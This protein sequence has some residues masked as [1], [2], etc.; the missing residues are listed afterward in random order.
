MR[1]IL[2]KII[3]FAVD[4]VGIIISIFLAYQLR[5]VA[6]FLEKAHTIP[7][8]DYLT[9]FP[10]YIVVLS[11]F[12]YEGIYTRRYDFWHETRLILKAL[13]FS[14]I[15]VLAYLALSKT[16]GNYS[17][18]VVI[19]SFLCM[20]FLIPVLKRVVKIALYKFGLW[21]KP[22]IIYGEDDLLQREIYSNPYLGYTEANEKDPKTV[23]INSRKMDYKTLKQTIDEQIGTNH[24]VIFIP[25][26]NDFDLTQSQIYELSNVRTNLISLQNRLKSRLRRVTKLIF[27]MFLALLL[28]PLLLPILAIIA[29]LIKKE[30]PEG[31]ILFKQERLGKDGKLFLCYKF[32]T[33]KEESDEL[34]QGYLKDHPEEIV[35]Y[36]KYHK[37][38]NDPRVT[39]IGA[40]LRKTSLDELPQI[41]NVLKM[42]MSF[43]GPRPYM[44]NEKKKMGEYFETIVRVRPGITG[45]WQVSGRSEVDFHSRV[46]MDVWYIRNWNL[47]MDIII[48]L[49][50]AKTVVVREGA[51]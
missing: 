22:A 31:S 43:V 49:K 37:Y 32:R 5:S 41:F 21:Q 30:E 50:T 8:H 24:E 25:L 9:L 40:I 48:L 29:L 13:L 47:W 11:I 2:S 14:L 39:K 17:R 26:L 51:Y 20:A 44:P 4:L 1:E 28:L 27:D 23:F 15:A 16:I 12:A 34:L 45:L 33:M 18:I 6:D 38:K 10:I 7:L 36:E 19:L 3:F 35:Y 46:D 42:E